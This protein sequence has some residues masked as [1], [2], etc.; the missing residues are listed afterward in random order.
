MYMFI[1]L[2][3]TSLAFDI[4]F[5]LLKFCLQSFSMGTVGSEYF[6]VIVLSVWETEWVYTA[7]MCGKSC[8][9]NFWVCVLRK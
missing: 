6:C 9:T 2:E 3:M 1:V 5:Y 8:E 4:L 7:Q